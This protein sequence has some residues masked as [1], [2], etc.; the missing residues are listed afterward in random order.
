MM[1][2]KILLPSVLTVTDAGTGLSDE[3]S[4]SPRPFVALYLG[5]NVCR[6]TEVSAPACIPSSAYQLP[7]RM[8]SLSHSLVRETPV[9]RILVV[10]FST[11][12]LWG[13]FFLMQEV[14]SSKEFLR[15]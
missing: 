11:F 15:V 10:H 2:W 3:F 4:L 6:K 12:Q 13:Q 9:T 14:R 7:F 1:R 5:W 8:N